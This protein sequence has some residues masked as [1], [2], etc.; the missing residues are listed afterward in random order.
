M[1]YE[2]NMQ[3]LFWTSLYGEYIDNCKPH[4]FESRE[5]VLVRV[6][7]ST[8]NGREESLLRNRAILCNMMTSWECT[9]Q[10]CYNEDSQRMEP[11]IITGNIL[12]N[13]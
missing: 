2:A 3:W 9:D 6:S 1:V 8:D 12:V 4:D 11:L 10:Y 13:A 5:P 7:P